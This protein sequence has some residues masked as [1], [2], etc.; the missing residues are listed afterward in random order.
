MVRKNLF[1]TMVRKKL[2][3][4]M[5][6]KNLLKKMIRMNMVKRMARKRRKL[7]VSFRSIRYIIG[8]TRT[9]SSTTARPM[10]F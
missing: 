4:T 7:K 3:K 2:V 10:D 8:N 5:I 1:K 6:R 9:S